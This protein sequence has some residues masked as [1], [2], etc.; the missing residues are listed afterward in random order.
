MVQA[1]YLGCHA[2]KIPVPQFNLLD[3][4]LEYTLRKP[5]DHRIP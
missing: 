5:S 4:Y 2:E 1:I 3:L